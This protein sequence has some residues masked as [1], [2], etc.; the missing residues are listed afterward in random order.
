[1]TLMEINCSDK[2]K[3]KAAFQ[4]DL[5]MRYYLDPS[6]FRR[7]TNK[8]CKSVNILDVFGNT[9]KIRKYEKR[10]VRH[11]SSLSTHPA[12]EV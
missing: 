5:R 8:K 6:L 10:N 3:F 1:M 4:T 7:N 11:Y 9:L 12:A 2:Q